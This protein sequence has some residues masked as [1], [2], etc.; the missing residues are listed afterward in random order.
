[1]AAET[2]KQL[3]GLFLTAD[4]DESGALGR[5]ELAQVLVKFYRQGWST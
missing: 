5:E 1:M 2:L 3:E 4:A